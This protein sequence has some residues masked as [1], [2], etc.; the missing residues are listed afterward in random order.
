MRDNRIEV[1]IESPDFP[2]ELIRVRALHGSERVSQLFRFEVTLVS[3]D[4]EGPG[5]PD[6]AGCV[7]ALVFLERGVEVRK[8][9]GM[10]SHA[11]DM[12]ETE[13][14][15][16]TYRVIVVPRAHRLTLVNVHDIYVSTSVVDIVKKKLALAGLA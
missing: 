11:V 1:R 7:V 15:Q 2:C 5:A 12:L 8:V 10:I 14:E 6:L 9:F 3:L 4:P 13:S 16:R